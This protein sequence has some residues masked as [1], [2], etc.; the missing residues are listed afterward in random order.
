MNFDKAPPAEQVMTLDRATNEELF[1]GSETE[2]RC[3]T[4]RFYFGTG[5]RWAF[6]RLNGDLE[7]LE[8]SKFNFIN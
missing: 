8:D 2:F 4:S 5:V 3:N 1:V 6:E 7:F